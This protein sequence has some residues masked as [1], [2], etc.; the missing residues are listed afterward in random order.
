EKR[1]LEVVNGVFARYRDTIQRESR[2]VELDLNIRFEMPKPQSRIELRT[3]GLAMVVRYPVPLHDAVQTADEIARRLVD[4]LRREPGL[5]LTSQG[6]ESLRPTP[7]VPHPSS[8]PS[9]ASEG[10][11]KA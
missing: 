1:I 3:T 7:V 6:T 9:S 11:G 5:E 2:R 8:A 10:T 4:A